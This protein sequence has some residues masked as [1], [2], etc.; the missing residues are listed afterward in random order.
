MTSS[1]FRRLVPCIVAVILCCGAT[2]AAPA[3]AAIVLATSLGLFERFLNTEPLSFRQW[4][5]CIGLALVVVV[6]AE[7]RKA[8]LRRREPKED[9]P[10]STG[11]VSPAPA[12]VA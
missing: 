9:V 1:L 10:K 12:P 6:V 7:A 8:F 5:V 2:V 3:R 11:E 4:L